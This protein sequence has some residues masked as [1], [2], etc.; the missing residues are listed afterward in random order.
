MLKYYKAGKFPF[1]RLIKKFPFDQIN[2]AAHASEKG[3][4]IKPVLVF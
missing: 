1:D 4:A 3:D 2:E